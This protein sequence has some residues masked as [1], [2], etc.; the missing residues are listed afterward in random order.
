MYKGNMY[1]FVDKVNN[2]LESK[3]IR[4]KIWIYEYEGKFT[5][6]VDLS[7]VNRE[8]SKGIIIIDNENFEQQVY[9]YL[10]EQ[11]ELIDY[12]V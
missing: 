12:Y 2:Y 1:E 10:K 3:G 8:N 5:L 4:L 9:E 6:F 11:P 7:T